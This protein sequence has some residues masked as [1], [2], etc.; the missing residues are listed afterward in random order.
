MPPSASNAAPGPTRL[1]FGMVP[2]RDDDETRVL[3]NGL[4]DYL[5][6]YS[7]LVVVPHRS[8]SPDALASAL[9]AGRVHVAWTGALSLL[10]SE[11][12]S[13]MVPL[14]SAVREGVA[15][16]H[17]QIFVPATSPVRDLES[18]RGS[19]IA[20]VSRSSASGY[21]VPRL[22]LARAGI[23]V[24]GYF[25][26]ERFAGSH[27]KAARAAAEGAVDLAAT[28]AIFENGDPSLRVVKSGYRTLDPDLEVRVLDTSGPIPGDLILV[29]PSVAPAVQRL[30]A[31][32]LVEIGSDPRAFE[33]MT[34]LMGADGF[35]RFTPLVLRE[36]QALVAV[37]RSSGALASGG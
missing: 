22:A 10:L 20:W 29:A 5:G 37:A 11:L 19:R 23:P 28:Y 31:T 25:S 36:V 30:V 26:E 34:E 4:C 32:A 6:R 9:H 35:T 13:G 14:L 2:Q 21:V 12:M 27:T 17:S 18:A 1:V 7:G 24:D 3:L 33:I 16:Y 8:P 15:F